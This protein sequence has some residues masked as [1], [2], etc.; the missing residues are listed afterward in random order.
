M[1]NRKNNIIKIIIV[2]I[3]LSLYS[4]LPISW[5]IRTSFLEKADLYDISSIMIGKEYTLG[6]Y[7]DIFGIDGGNILVARNFKEAFINSLVTSIIATAIICIIAVLAGYVFARVKTKLSR[8]L[9]SLLLVTMVL[10][11]Y[12]VMIPL[13][14]IMMS[15][16]LLDTITG[17]VLIYISAYMPLAIWIMKNFFESIPEEIEEAA[18]IDGASKLKSMFIVLPMIAPGIIASAIIS[19]LSSWGQYAIPLV[20]ATS[21]AQPLTVF[22]TTLN[23]KASINFGLI[24]AG[25]IISIIPPV[26]IVIF[27][28]RYLVGGLS[29]G[30]IK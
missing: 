23:E 22:L 26:L 13:Y 15:I 4:I 21:E 29:K 7:K 18:Q 6:Y 5:M 1:I 19:F 12:S 14:K 9:F 16:S 10:P 3:I 17:V 8:F 27:L 25:G 11:A 24:S 30:A 20:F 2:F 28:N